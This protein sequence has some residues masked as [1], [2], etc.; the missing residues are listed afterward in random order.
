MSAGSKTNPGGYGND[1][2]L[3]QFEISDNRTAAEVSNF[4]YK[5]GYDTIWKDW[6]IAYDSQNHTPHRVEPGLSGITV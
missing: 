5:F 1:D 4:L 3:E 6:D 2:S